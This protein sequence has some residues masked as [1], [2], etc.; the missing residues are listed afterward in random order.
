MAYTLL[1]NSCPEGFYRCHWSKLGRI[2]CTQASAAIDERGRLFTWGQNYWGQCGQGDKSIDS[3]LHEIEFCTQL[4]NAENWIKV[5]G[6]EACLMAIN[7][8]GALWAWGSNSDDCSQWGLPPGTYGSVAYTPIRCTPGYLFKD[9]AFDGYHTI[10]I[11]QDDKL[12]SFGDNSYWALG[13]GGVKGNPYATPQLNPTITEDVKLIDCELFCNVAVTVSN[14]VYAFGGEGWWYSDNVWETY[15][16]GVPWEVTGLPSGIDVIDVKLTYWGI[17]VLLEDGTVWKAGDSGFLCDGTGIGAGGTDNFVQVTEFSAMNITKIRLTGLGSFGMFVLSDEGNIYGWVDEGEI[18]WSGNSIVAANGQQHLIGAEYPGNVQF[19]D[20]AVNSHNQFA[21]AIDSNGWLWTWGTQWWGSHLGI[22]AKSRSGSGTLDSD[23]YDVVATRAAA[24]HAEPALDYNGQPAYLN[25]VKSTA[26][27]FLVTPDQAAWHL[28]CGHWHLRLFTGPGPEFP[29]NCWM[30]S[31]DAD[32]GK[33][34]FVAAG[35]HLGLSPDV[36]CDIIFFLFDPDANTWTELNRSDLRYAADSPGGAAMDSGIYAFANYKADAH[37][38]RITESFDNFAFGVW[39][40]DGSGNLEYTQ[41]TDAI[42]QSGKNKIGVYTG[43][44]VVFAYEDTSGDINVMYSSDYGAS[45]GNIKTVAAAGDF[46][47]VVNSS[48]VIYFATQITSSAVKVEKSTNWGGS[49]NTITASNSVVSSMNYVKI[50]SDLSMLYLICGSSS[51]AVAV[52]RSSNDG[53]SWGTISGEP[54]SI[55][56][57]YASGVNDDNSDITIA[58][59]DTEIHTYYYDTGATQYQWDQVADIITQE[60]NSTMEGDEG[61]FVYAAFAYIYPGTGRVG[62]AVSRDN[63]RHWDTDQTPLRYFGTAAEITEF[64]GD[65]LFYET[66]V[67]YLN[68]ETFFNPEIP[69]TRDDWAQTFVRQEDK[70]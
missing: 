12:Y 8:E 30:P 56:I 25:N 20:M 6:G 60:L 13:I 18:S 36:G 55:P 68:T 59:A 48:G 4:T 46:S 44:H 50:V 3:R 5:G 2:S 28:P 15:D 45:W 38:T 19:V 53:A 29:Y 69:F 47:L 54:S 17:V 31:V 32:D 42:V 40:V 51:G 24:A 70:Y 41:W 22:G 33:V 27:P 11:G 23:P 1:T 21:M 10:A 39:V 63:G 66:D 65:P 49:W 34:L 26:H 35:K 7:R 58:L 62:I 43:G 61:T 16:T 9:F 37:G 64:D 52:E 67:P 14:K 57:G